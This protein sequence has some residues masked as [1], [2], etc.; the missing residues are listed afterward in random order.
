MARASILLEQLE[1]KDA[2]GCLVIAGNKVLLLQRSRYTT[3]PLKWGIPG[4]RIDKQ[5][6][7]PL[8]AALRETQEE[9]NLDLSYYTPIKSMRQPLSEEP[10]YFTTYV[11]R[12]PTIDPEWD[13]KIDHESNAWGWFTLKETEKLD[14]HPSMSYVLNRVNIGV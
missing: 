8:A 9:A 14:L 10:G 13:I 1:A 5:D 11:Y 2:A 3:L 12:F 6:I 4:G 7:N